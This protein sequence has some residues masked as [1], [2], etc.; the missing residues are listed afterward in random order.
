[1]MARI[2]MYYQ[3]TTPASPHTLMVIPF[4]RSCTYTLLRQASIAIKLSLRGTT[5]G[6]ASF[7]HNLIKPRSDGLVSTTDL[8]IEPPPE[9]FFMLAGLP[10]PPQHKYHR[11]VLNSAEMTLVRVRTRGVS[12]ES[13]LPSNSAFNTIMNYKCPLVFPLNVHR[14]HG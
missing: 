10:P 11:S 6:V 12:E 2:R 14:C 1:M 5:D 9:E 8:L 7:V 13:L 3:S 4:G